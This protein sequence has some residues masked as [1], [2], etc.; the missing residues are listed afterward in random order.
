MTAEMTP[1]MVPSIHRTGVESDGRRLPD[2]VCAHEHG[3]GPDGERGHR[4]GAVEVRDHGIGQVAARDLA[5]PE[6]VQDRRD[7]EHDQ[8]EC[9]DHPHDL[10]EQPEPG[11]LHR[12]R[13][14]GGRD[15]ARPHDRREPVRCDVRDNHPRRFELSEEASRGASRRCRGG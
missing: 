14:S 10:S 15:D 11:D 2:E 1:R 12:Q 8:Q 13:R 4:G 6:P 7:R 9:R 5:E 3:A